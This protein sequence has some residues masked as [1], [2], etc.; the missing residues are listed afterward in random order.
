MSINANDSDARSVA[1]GVRFKAVFRPFRY[2]FFILL[3]HMEAK[4]STTPMFSTVAS[5]ALIALLNAVTLLVVITEMTGHSILNVAVT[6]TQTYPLMILFGVL[7]YM[8]INVAW[9]RN[10][11]LA[12]L[13][14][15]FQSIPPA[16]QHRNRIIFWVY[17]FGSVLALPLVGIILSVV[18]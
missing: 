10:G 8:V 12:A 17:A 11:R 5:M 13:R 2:M 1:P 18:R 14:A 15:E 4:A 9:I 3:T 16:R 6:R 7:L